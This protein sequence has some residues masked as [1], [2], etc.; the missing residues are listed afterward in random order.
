M[1]YVVVII[2]L[3]GHYT[4]KCEAFDDTVIALSGLNLRA[5]PKI[6]SEKLYVIPF[7]DFVSSNVNHISGSKIKTNENILI[8]DHYGIWIEVKYKTFKGYVFSAFIIKGK[9][10]IESFDGINDNYRILQEGYY[11]D[12]VNYS[13]NLNWYGLY[14]NNDSLYLEKVEVQL[15]FKHHLTPEEIQKDDFF[16]SYHIKV[17]TN[18]N[19]RSSLLIGTDS[20]LQTNFDFGKQKYSFIDF[21]SSNRNGKFFYPEEKHAF[22]QTPYMY[23]ISAKD[24]VII[25][26]NSKLGYRRHYELSLAL[27]NTESRKKSQIFFLGGE[28]T[29][30]DGRLHALFKNPKLMW[31]GDFNNDNIHDFILL[32]SDMSESCG[33]C[34]Y[35]VLYM[36]DSLE[37]INKKAV[38][39]M[40]GG[41]ES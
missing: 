11:C 29:T 18:N 33:S 19:K 41:C 20:I 9:K 24:N 31:L 1:R 21:K 30:S 37:M 17:E 32:D 25:D 38:L 6:D 15:K 5:E 34:S 22:F 40:C 3:L 27:E 13:P 12:A 2:I 26:S 14:F 36:S 23:T 7:G 28:S 16:I 8:G 35:F 4:V 10:I 39:T